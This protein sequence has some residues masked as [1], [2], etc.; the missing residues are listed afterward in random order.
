MNEYTNMILYAVLYVVS[1]KVLIVFIC[2][3]EA[4]IWHISYCGRSGPF[5][6]AK[7]NI[8]QTIMSDGR[9]CYC[10]QYFNLNFPGEMEMTQE[11]G[12]R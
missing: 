3:L 1:I 9:K 8:L 11:F 2:R 12:V 5:T 10:F 7:S 4:E 6:S